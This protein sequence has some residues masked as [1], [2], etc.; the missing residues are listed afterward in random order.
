M[1]IEKELVGAC[2]ITMGRKQTPEATLGHHCPGE[3]DKVIFYILSSI[4]SL[5][6]FMNI[7]QLQYVSV[8]PSHISS[9]HWVRV[10]R[11]CYTRQKRTSDFLFFFVPCCI[12]HDV[13]LIQEIKFGRKTAN[14]VV[15]SLMY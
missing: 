12:K 8:Q 3:I 6:Y 14:D 9:A 5:R 11:S 13:Y 2:L 10:A 15:N 1:K 7:L 4:Q